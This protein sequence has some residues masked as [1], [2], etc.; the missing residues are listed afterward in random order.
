MFKKIEIW[1]LYLTILLSI[2]LAIG[3]GVL[4]RQ[5]IEGTTKKGNIDISFLSKPA[6]YIAR[7]PERLLKVTLK[8]NANRVNDPWD[9]EREFFKQDG[10]DGT[11]K[12]EESYLLL[13]R[14]D[15]DLQEGVVELVDLTNFEILHTWNP[16]IDAFND[17]VEQVDEFKYLERDSN[18]K[19]KILQH[20]KLT[21]EGGLLFN[22]WTPSPLLKIDA[23]SNLVFQNT[24][25]RFGHFY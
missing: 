6:A 15:G 12:F 3:F 13:S 7:L 1:I 23:C 14:H 16:D 22:G 10:F 9:D 25:D 17:L 4:V 2:L 18:N 20:P 19:R 8:T 24:H 11:P 21:K 5:E